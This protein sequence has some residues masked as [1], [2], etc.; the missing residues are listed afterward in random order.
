MCANSEVSIRSSRAWPRTLPLS[1]GLLVLSVGLFV[2][3]FAVP[4]AGQAGSTP[5]LGFGF[6]WGSLCAASECVESVNGAG[7]VAAYTRPWG[8]RVE[9]QLSTAFWYGSTREET[10]RRITASVAARIYPSTSAPVF[11]KG[12]GGLSWDPDGSGADLAGLLGV[13]W[14]IRG[15]IGVVVTPFI[16]AAFFGS[17]DPLPTLRL[18]S[19]GVQVGWPL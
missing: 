9:G 8:E 12:G 19:G 1:L 5:T 7:G 6:Y 17:S 3:P 4:V 2:G 15:L 18:I 16:D 13:G 10:V 11:V 14:D